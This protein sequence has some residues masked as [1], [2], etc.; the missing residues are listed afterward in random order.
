MSLPQ[1][2]YLGLRKEKEASLWQ[3]HVVP[4]A[5][6]PKPLPSVSP[7]RM[8]G[9]SSDKNMQMRIKSQKTE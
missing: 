5:P 3:G 7:R 2:I 8:L 1:D 6:R 4:R 9:Q